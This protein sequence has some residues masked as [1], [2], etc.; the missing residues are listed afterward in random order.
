MLAE[1]ALYHLSY[2]PD[3]PGW[4]MAAPGWMYIDNLIIALGCRRGLPV[5]GGSLPHFL[6]SYS[7][8]D[9]DFAGTWP[10][11]RTLYSQG[12][13]FRCPYHFHNV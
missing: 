2:A 10:V 6:V 9:C 5:W 3:N 13:A 8:L 7:L 1:H 4:P 12:S 11:P